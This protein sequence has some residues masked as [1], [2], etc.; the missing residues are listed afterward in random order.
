MIKKTIKAWLAS[1]VFFNLWSLITC[2]WLFRWVYFAEPTE[3]LRR[4]VL[5]LSDGFFGLSF[6]NN[7]ILTGAFSFIYALTEKILPGGRFRKGLI[8]GFFIWL[9]SWLLP[10]MRFVISLNL[11]IALSVYWCMN[12]LAVYVL[13]GVVIGFFYED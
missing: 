6:L 2:G 12:G 1:A 4:G 9:V 10:F 13:T 5:S 11:S 8:F 3:A 7:L